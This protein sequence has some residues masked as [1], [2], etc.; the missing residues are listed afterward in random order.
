MRQRAT[1]LHRSCRYY[2]YRDAFLFDQLDFKTPC[3]IRAHEVDTLLN[4]QADDEDLQSLS[5]SHPS[6]SRPSA[7]TPSRSP[8]PNNGQGS[9]SSSSNPG[10][11]GRI[12][13]TN[14][15]K[16]TKST[17]WGVKTE[18]RYT[19]EST[20]DEPVSKTIVRTVS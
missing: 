15:P 17:T 5:F 8:L 9:S 4:S 7:P 13:S 3:S 19:G 20:L 12:G 2:R 16:S 14:Q 1:R 6:S 11:S 18:T 10:L